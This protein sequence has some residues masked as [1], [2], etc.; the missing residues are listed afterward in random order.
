MD[1]FSAIEPEL[2][3]RR[4]FP[5]SAGAFESNWRALAKIAPS[6][7]CFS[8][9]CIA[10]WL[11]P[12]I[13][14]RMPGAVRRTGER[15]HFR[16]PVAGGAE[17]ASHSAG[18]AD[19]PESAKEWAYGAGLAMFGTFREMNRLVEEMRENNITV[20]VDCG[21]WPRPENR[22]TRVMYPVILAGLLAFFLVSLQLGSGAPEPWSL[23]L[24]ILAVCTLPGMFWAI[25]KIG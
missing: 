21:D 7:R 14:T 19:E 17:A 11:L 22:E 23:M 2:K 18:W 24:K 12:D 5:T 13:G 8:I 25:S 6:V 15:R 4:W 10:I 9:A 16:S 3:I 1:E 20:G